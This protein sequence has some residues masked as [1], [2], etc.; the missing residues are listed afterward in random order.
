[1]TELEE[2]LAKQ[3]AS[4]LNKDKKTVDMGDEEDFS[5]SDSEPDVDA[6]EEE[7]LQQILPKQFVKKHT[8]RRKHRRHGRHNSKKGAAATA[9]TLLT[10]QNIKTRECR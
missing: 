5:G 2:N 7:V 4:N 6:V 8:K 3:R 9:N 1:M 10:Q